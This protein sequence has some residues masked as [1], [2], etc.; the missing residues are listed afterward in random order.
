MLDS[1]PMHVKTDSGFLEHFGYFPRR[2]FCLLLHLTSQSGTPHQT[3]EVRALSL[4]SAT[5]DREGTKSPVPRGSI[6]ATSNYA[7]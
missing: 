2:A 3:V 7:T 5:T 6:G 4:T 1:V